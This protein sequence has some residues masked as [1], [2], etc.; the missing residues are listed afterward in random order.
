M[1]VPIKYIPQLA[2][3]WVQTRLLNKKVPLF[4]EW[5]ITF[6]CPYKC[7][8]CGA[9]DVEMKELGTEEVQKR[10]ES[11]YKLGVRWITFGGG[12]PLVRKDI[13]EILRSAKHLGFVVYLST[14]G[15]NIE[16]IKDIEQ[17]VDHI[18]L[19]FD[20]PP[21]IHN[22][23]RGTGSYQ[24]LFEVLGFCKQKSISISF[25]CVISLLN[26]GAIDYVL[27]KSREVGVPVM[28]QPATLHL[29]SS[30]KANPIAPPVDAYRESIER[31]IKAKKL[32]Y[33]I[34]NS[35]AGLRYLQ[36]WPEAHNIWCPA[37]RLSFTIEPDGSVLSCH[38]WERDKLFCSYNSKEQDSFEEKLNKLCVPRGCSSC[39]CA[40]LVELALI[41]DINVSAIWNALWL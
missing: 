3:R 24:R 8:Y 28:F 29:D 16:R 23:I 31:I 32:G 26:I 40:P 1:S 7:L 4:A 22:H 17:Y 21:E 11:I 9:S 6:R 18:N 34:R 27:E 15:T 20:G 2:Y 25:L 19:S 36:H 13:V 39:W 35:I 38:M 41:W 14:T 37:G 10:L 12:E 33:L 5:N 30:L